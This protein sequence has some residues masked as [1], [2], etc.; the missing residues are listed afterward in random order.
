MGI[1]SELVH[2]DTLNIERAGRETVSGTTAS[3]EQGEPTRSSM[4]SWSQACARIL[5]MMSETRVYIETP[6]ACA[7][8]FHDL[9]KSSK[10]RQ[11]SGYWVGTRFFISAVARTIRE[12]LRL[13][14]VD[15]EGLTLEPQSTVERIRDLG[16]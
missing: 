8:R 4:I 1:S 5:S 2:A 3:I 11:A 6:K 9:K 16:S 7:S 13:V 15:E 10:S 12:V 14:R